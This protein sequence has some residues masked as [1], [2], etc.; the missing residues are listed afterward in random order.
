MLGFMQEHG[1][2][3]MED[4]NDTFHENEWSWNKEANVLYI[5]SPA[6]VGYSYYI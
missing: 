2:Y 4:G 3:V 5:E 1:P 6:A